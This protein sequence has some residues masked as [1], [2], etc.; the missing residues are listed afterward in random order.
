MQKS[1]ELRERKIEY[2]LRVSKRA[3]SMRLAIYHDGAFVVT[4]P[5]RMNPWTVD[6]FIIK[7]SQWVID[8]LEYFK[9]FSGV[10]IVKSSKRDF[11]KYKD[12]TLALAQRR[13]AYFNSVY[14]FKFNAISIRNQKTRWGS[15]SRKRNLNFNYKIAL[16]PE[17]LADYII[18]HELCHLEE[19][20]HS[21]RFW[22]LVA[23]TIPNYVELR[24]ELKQGRVRL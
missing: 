20:N 19:F 6:Q 13:I 23:T 8:K 7:K 5:Q 1:I 14:Q 3:R 10:P 15:C 21:R 24:N 12:Q 16:L 17:R 11:A 2:T 18:V 9:S 4:V 22:S